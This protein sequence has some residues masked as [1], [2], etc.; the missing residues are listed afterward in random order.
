MFN[1]Y[2]NSIIL[3]VLKR[4]KGNPIDDSTRLVTVG[5]GTKNVMIG[6]QTLPKQMLFYFPQDKFNAA[7]LDFYIDKLIENKWDIHQIQGDETSTKKFAEAYSKKTKKKFERRMNLVVYKLDELCKPDLPNGKM[8]PATLDDMN[9]LPFWAVAFN[10]ECDLGIE[11]NCLTTQRDGIIQR[12][13]ASPGTRFLWEVNGRPVSM[14][15]YEEIADDEANIS[16]VYT[17]P[18]FRG[19]KYAFGLVW[20]ICNKIRAKYKNIML[21]ADANYPQ[22]NKVYQRIGFRELFI[23]SQYIFEEA[24]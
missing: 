3:R 16:G 14:A 11:G 15:H 2:Q 22:S 20:S 8:R 1:K 4:I 19:N 12:F 18:D 6:F 21:Y 7:A 9:I 23:N 24:K 10:I 17:P 13:N 5:D